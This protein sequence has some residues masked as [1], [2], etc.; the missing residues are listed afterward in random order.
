MQDK[1]N[2]KKHTNFKNTTSQLQFMENFERLFE[3]GHGKS[4]KGVHCLNT[5][6]LN[7]FI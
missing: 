6:V 5:D 1:N 7:F 3:K 4:C 2:K